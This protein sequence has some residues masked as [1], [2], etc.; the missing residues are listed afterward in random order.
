MLYLLFHTSLIHVDNN[1]YI[2]NNKLGTNCDM[3]MYV[4]F[5]GNKICILYGINS[6]KSFIIIEVKLLLIIKIR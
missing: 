1:E 3:N 4:I 2:H 6:W 5:F